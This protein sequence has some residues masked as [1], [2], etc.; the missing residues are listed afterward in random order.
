MDSTA[1]IDNMSDDESDEE[2]SSSNDYTD[3]LENIYFVMSNLR[4]EIEKHINTYYAVT[5]WILYVITHIKEDVFKKS[6]GNHRNQMN[7]AIKTLFSCSY[8]K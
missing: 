8:E 3:Y 2:D 7:T 5:G 1:N 4:I 6:S